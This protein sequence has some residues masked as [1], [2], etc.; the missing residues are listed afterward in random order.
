MCRTLNLMVTLL[1]QSSLQYYF[2]SVIL[3]WCWA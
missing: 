3:F 1:F 2:C